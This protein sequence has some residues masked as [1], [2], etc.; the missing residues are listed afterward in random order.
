MNKET[1]VEVLFNS[2]KKSMLIAYV[3]GALFGGFGVHYFVL[4]EPF[5]GVLTI[6]LFVLGVVVPPV[7]VANV[8]WVLW[9]VIHTKMVCEAKNKEIRLMCEQLVD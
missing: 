2:K 7:M 6:G 4:D 1:Q 3:L 8:I 5:Y 9:G